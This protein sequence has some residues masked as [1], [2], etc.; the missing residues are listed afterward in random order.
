LFPELGAHQ[1]DMD[2]LKHLEAKTAAE[3]NVLLP[4]ILD[5]AFKGQ[6]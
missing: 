1:L 5:K 4:A 2:A 6:L 3:L